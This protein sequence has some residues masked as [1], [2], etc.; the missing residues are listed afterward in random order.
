[1]DLL[2]AGDW[3]EF[4]SAIHDVTDTFFDLPVIYAQ[5]RTRKLSKFHENRGDD[6]EVIGYNLL[7]FNVPNHT[8]ESR[9]QAEALAKGSAD[10]SQGYLSFSYL[11]LKNNTPSMIDVNGNPVFIPGKDTFFALGQ[12][13]NILSVNLVGPSETDYQLVKVQYRKSLNPGTPPI[14][15]KIF[16][17]TFDE[18]FQ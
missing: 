10:F 6:L 1:M 2:S 16:D 15:A 13:L 9:S 14:I 4:R 11:D 7:S 5:R 18:T 3:L 17:E 12:E 8:D